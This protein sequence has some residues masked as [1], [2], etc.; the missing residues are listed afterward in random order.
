MSFVE[1][2]FPSDISFGAVG[3]A[4]FSTDIIRTFGGYEQRNSN[5]NY[6]LGE[7][8]VGHGVKNAA[9]LDALIAFFWARKGRHVG[10]RFKDWSDYKVT[11]GNI[12]TG[13]GATANFQLRKQY[14]SGGVTINRSIKKPVSGTVNVYVN[15]V[16]KTITTHFT[17]NTTTGTITFT[18]GNIPSAGQVI[19]SDFE[20]DVPARFDTDKIDVSLDSFQIGSWPNI[21][22]VELRA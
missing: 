12:G 20:F 16:L 17:V 21:P 14:T 7:W 18:G 9:Q 1:T 11:A 8:N 6:P 13:D 4:R 5:W 22:V 10:F 3:G 19:T 15:G 2:Q